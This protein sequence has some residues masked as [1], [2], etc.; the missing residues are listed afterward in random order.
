MMST[1]VTVAVLAVLAVLMAMR[2]VTAVLT[3]IVA[4][5]TAVMLAVVVAVN[6]WIISK[7][8]LYQRLSSII[9]IALHTAIETNA[10]LCQCILRP[11]TD[12]ATDERIDGLVLE[13]GCQCTMSSAIAFQDMRFCDLAI[14]N[15]IDLKGLRLA[16]MLENLAIVVG[17]C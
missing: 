8:V 9:C 13:Q 1:S 16:E 3:V 11:G 7:P 17:N 4:G 15:R 10:S 14:L 12:P 2:A 6:G 5:M